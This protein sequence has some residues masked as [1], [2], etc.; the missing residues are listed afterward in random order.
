[1][2]LEPRNECM[3]RDDLGQLQ[4]ERLQSSLHRATRNVAF[5]K[6]CFDAAEVDTGDMKE[7][8]SA[9]GSDP[10]PETRANGVRPRGSDTVSVVIRHCGSLRG[11]RPSLRSLAPP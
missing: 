2:V 4:I 5:Y 11:S 1:M 8:N 10:M 3:S 6:R 7:L 9:I